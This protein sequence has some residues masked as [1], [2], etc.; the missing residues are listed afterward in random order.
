MFESEF[1]RS[2]FAL[3]QEKLQA[4]CC[5]GSR[6]LSQPLPHHPRYP[7]GARAF[8]WFYSGATRSRAAAGIDRRPHHGHPRSGQGRF[9]PAATGRRTATN[10][11]SPGCRRRAGLSALQAARPGRPHRRLRLRLPHPHRRAHRPCRNDHLPGQGHARAAGEV[12]R[13]GRR[14]ASLPAALRRPV[15]E[16]RCARGLRQ[17]RPG[18]QGHPIVSSISADTSR[19]RPR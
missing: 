7:G 12:S 5:A 19:W 13:A 9:C 3:R 4:D 1:E 18:A 2:L 16:H 10:L 14:G 15:H 11:R 6:R 17:A 8:R